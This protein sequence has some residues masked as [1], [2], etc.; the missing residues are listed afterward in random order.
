[1]QKDKNKLS[2]RQQQLAEKIAK[3]ITGLQKRLAD[4]LSKATSH[5]SPMEWK[6]FLIVFVALTASYCLRLILSIFN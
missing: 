5:L 1:M 6:V 3:K 4:R 2:V